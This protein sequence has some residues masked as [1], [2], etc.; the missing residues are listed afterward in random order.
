M[1]VN[2]STFT[3]PS[4]DE[5]REMFRRAKARQQQLEEKGRKMWEEEQ[6]IKA[7]AK[8]YYEFDYA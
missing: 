6:R 5:I 4:H 3:R 2:K 8:Q 1:E 7:E